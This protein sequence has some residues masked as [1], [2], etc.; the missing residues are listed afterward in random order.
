MGRIEQDFTNIYGFQ[1][2]LRDWLLFCVIDIMHP[3]APA[4]AVTGF[5]AW[6]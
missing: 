6:A 4:L 3:M 1:S 5:C 2:G